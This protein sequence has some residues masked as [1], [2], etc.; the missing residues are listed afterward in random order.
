[1]SLIHG[2]LRP[3][4]SGKFIMEHGKLIKIN[5][6]GVHR[7][8]QMIYDAV[9]D[10]S[11]AEVEFSAH[12]VHPKG[13]GREVIDWV[14][15]AD[16]VNFSFWPDKG[17]KYDVTYGGTKYTGYFAAC[18]A[19]NKALDS[20][21]NITSA[22][23]MASASKEDV[24]N[25][26]KSDGGYSI[27]LLDERV[28]AIND[29]GRVLLEK[30]NGSFYNC[31]LAAEGSAERLLN[32]IV[33]NFESFRDFAEFC[34]KKVSFLKRAQILVADVYGAL[35]DNDPACAFPDIEIL[36][37]FAD[38]RVPQALAFL[39]VLEYSKELLDALTPNHRLENG[40]PEEVELRGASIWAC[41]RIVQ[42]IKKLRADEGDV[43]RPIYAMDVDIFAW[44]YRRKHAVEI[45]KKKFDEKEDI[46]GATQLKSSI[47]K[48]IRN[49]IIELYPH[50]EPYLLDILPKKEN[51]KLIKCKDHV[52]LL[53]DHNGVVQ[54]LKTRNTDW[55]PTLRSFFAGPGHIS[56][57]ISRSAKPIV[58]V[59]N[60]TPE[61]WLVNVDKGAIKFVLNGSSIMC[62]GLTS[63][64][65]KM[66]PGVPAEAVVAVMA[67]G[68]QHALAIGQMKMSSEEIQSV[69]KGI[70]IE[71]VHYLTDGLWR[72]AEKPVN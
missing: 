7:V 55:I 8:A 21:L 10:G 58:P 33:E 52:E 1:M 47:Q 20:G 22:K 12:A 56:P 68:K 14:F 61:F 42:A 34:G 51:F 39:G 50:I 43:V 36:T 32:I 40:S 71:N 57:M 15:F 67:E 29:S 9:K 41:E 24:D 35:K 46:T 11:I 44:V 63:P 18:A 27:P 28:K 65:A 64:G 53:A 3:L 62:P 31:V 69:N 5:E 25:V 30:W 49:K 66:T 2:A 23:W 6:D 45:E 17:S 59:L 48:G 37:M 60:I 26:F 16:T 54:F 70:G 4:D 19:I 13:K 38:Y 72:L